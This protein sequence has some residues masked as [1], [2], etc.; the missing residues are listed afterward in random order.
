SPLEQVDHE[1]AIYNWLADHDLD[2]SNAQVLADTGVT[3][4]ALNSLA[5][6]VPGPAL[7]DV[8]RWAAAGC[9]VRRL[10]SEIQDSSARISSLVVAIKGFTHMDQAM[11]AERVNPSLGLR[12]TVTV[13]NSKATEKSVTVTTNFHE[14][15]PQV[16]GFAAE[17]NQIW[18]IL[19][20]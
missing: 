7:N 8:L 4:E 1:D 20:D 13:L 10:A 15:L 16:F 19:I 2:V 6:V 12:D 17:L 3:F 9:A 18:G 14:D 11:V 5:K